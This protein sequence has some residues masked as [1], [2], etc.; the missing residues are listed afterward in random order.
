MENPYIIIKELE[1]ELRRIRRDN[2]KLKMH[3][4]VLINHPL[5]NASKK[6]REK[7]NS[8]ARVSKDLFIGSLN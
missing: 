8:E 1:K 3:M 6:I 7:Y 2:L 5:I 4:Q